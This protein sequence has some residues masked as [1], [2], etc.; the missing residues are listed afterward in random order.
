MIRLGL[1]IGGGEVAV[2]VL[3][4]ARRELGEEL[5]KLEGFGKQG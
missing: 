4:V 1:G 3:A 5:F 2:N